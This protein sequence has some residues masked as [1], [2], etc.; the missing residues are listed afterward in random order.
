MTAAAATTTANVE[1]VQELYA[2]FGRGD[3]PAILELVSEDVRWEDWADSFAQR[4]SV[5]H[6]VP[7]SGR[8]GVREFFEIIATFD[9]SEFAVLDVMA[10]ERQV[11]AEIVIDATNPDG[12]RYRDEELHLWTFDADGRICRMRHY[13]DTAKHIAAT[14]GEDTTRG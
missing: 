11:V 5:P 9:V 6:L 3:V 10:G 14:A 2:A 12:G 13:V 4:A 8:D 1:A 7:R